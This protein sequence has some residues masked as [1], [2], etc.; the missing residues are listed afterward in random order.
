MEIMGNQ[1]SVAVSKPPSKGENDHRT[2]FVNN[3]SFQTTD[4]ELET[5]FAEYGEI[6]EVRLIKDE[7]GKPKGYGYV[8]FSSEEEAETAISKMDKQRISGRVLSVMK[9]N[10][11]RKEK[12]ESDRTVHISNIPYEAAE[13]QIET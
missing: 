7:R 12:Q 9:A 3:L 10:S 11:V 1:C 4:A 6:T 8:E 13:M 5:L 2:V